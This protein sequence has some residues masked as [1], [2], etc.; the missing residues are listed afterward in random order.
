MTGAAVAA[1]TH[2]SGAGGTRTRDDVDHTRRKIG[3]LQDLS[4]DQR[5]ERRGLRG[6]EHDGVPC[7][8]GGGELPCEHQQWEVPG[9]DLPGDTERARVRSEPGVVELVGPARV[10]EEPGC[11]EGHVDV[12]ALLDRLA[13]VEALG[14]RELTSPLLHE[15]GDA[16][17]VLAPIT[18]AH[19]RPGLVVCATGGGDRAIDVLIARGR[20]LGDAGLVGG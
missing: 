4:E 11:D 16:E 18:T 15:T 20:D 2:E 7:G 3:L 19:L 8:Q 5:R 17:Q 9:D 12:A 6:L 13:V 10:V 14:D 1:V